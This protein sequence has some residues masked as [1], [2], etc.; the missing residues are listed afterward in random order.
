MIHLRKATL[1][2]PALL[3]VT[4]LAIPAVVGGG[5]GRPPAATDAEEPTY[6]GKT[7]VEWHALAMASLEGAYCSACGEVQTRNDVYLVQ[8]RTRPILC[9][10]CNR[11]LYQ[12]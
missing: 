10:G 5:S 3:L 1:W 7:A 2:L 12:P 6:A 4:G 11:I 8:N 9:R